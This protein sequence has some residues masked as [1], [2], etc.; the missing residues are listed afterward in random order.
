MA[1][2]LAVLYSGILNIEPG[3]FENE[4]RDRFLLSKGHACTSLYAALALKGFFPLE[5]LGT[6]GTNGTILMSHTNHKVPGVELSTGSLGHALPVACGMSLAAKRKKMDYRSFVLLGDGEMNEGSNW[7]SIL[8]AQHHKLDNL[9]A[10]IDYNKI[11]SFGRTDVVMRLE[12]L[13]DKFRAFNW[14]VKEVD[15]HNH[16]KLWSVLSNLEHNIM[17]KCIIAHTIKG[18][19]VS[20]MEDK[21]LWHYRSPNEAEYKNALFEL[22]K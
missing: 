8:F 21:L 9:V 4:N 19:G 11:Q 17:P 3:D 10:I 12:P 7:E 13:A 14:E 2:I 1:D 16:E 20:F 22:G 18:K 6:Y 5:L 15:G